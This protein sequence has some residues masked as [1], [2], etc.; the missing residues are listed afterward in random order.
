MG[1]SKHISN[2]AK[3][4]FYTNMQLYPNLGI[5]QEIHGQNIRKIQLHKVAL[6]VFQLMLVSIHSELDQLPKLGYLNL[7]TPS[8]SKIID[9]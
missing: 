9:V 1:R 8:A 5:E 3:L 4:Y 2:T 7:K 6:S